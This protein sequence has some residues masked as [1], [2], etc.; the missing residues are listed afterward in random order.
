MR[1]LTKHLVYWTPRVLCIAF[2]AF[3]ALFALDVFSMRLDFP[4]RMLAL[5][6]HL[7]PSFVVLIALAIVW[8]REWIAAVIFPLLAVFHVVTM[9]GLHWS[10]YAVIDGPLL[11]LAVLFLLSWRERRAGFAAGRA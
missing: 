7:I 6:M 3:L 10:G 2:A 9:R 8:R 1:G 4:R 5:A 11:L